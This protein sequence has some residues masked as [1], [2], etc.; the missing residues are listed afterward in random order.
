MKFCAKCNK[1][2]P[3][4]EWHDYDTN[5]LSCWAL[6]GSRPKSVS[7]GWM[8]RSL[9]DKLVQVEQKKL[10]EELT[11]VWFWYD[12]IPTNPYY[13]YGTDENTPYCGLYHYGI[14]VSTVRWHQPTVTLEMVERFLNTSPHYQRLPGWSP[15]PKTI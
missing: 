13:E 11:I 8:E 2:I 12:L 1:R 3:D 9:F 6:A 15:V 14:L 5:C 7:T 4:Q 10:S